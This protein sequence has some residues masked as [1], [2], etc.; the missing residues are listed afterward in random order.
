M[1]HCN[2]SIYNNQKQQQ[3]APG[4]QVKCNLKLNSN[5]CMFHVPSKSYFCQVLEIKIIEKVWALIRPMF[6]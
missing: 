2:Q 3:N 6:I 5:G 4:V 1:R